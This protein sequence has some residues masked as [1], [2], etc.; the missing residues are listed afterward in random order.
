M[1]FLPVGGRETFRVERIDGRK[2]FDKEKKNKG[3]KWTNYGWGKTP[4]YIIS[5]GSVAK[6]S[7]HNTKPPF[8]SVLGG[9]QTEEAEERYIE[10]AL[11]ILFQSYTNLFY[12]CWYDFKSLFFLFILQPNNFTLLYECPLSI[13]VFHDLLLASAPEGTNH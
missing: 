13:F 9:H 4:K 8:S 5:F 1:R 7:V 10:T 2:T 12:F 3:K 6:G 11:S